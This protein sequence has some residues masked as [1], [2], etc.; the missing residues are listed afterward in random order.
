M[1]IQTVTAAV[2]SF[3]LK[4]SYETSSTDS[5][6]PISMGIPAVTIGRGGPGGRGHSLDE[7]TDVDRKGSVQAALVAVTIFLAAAGVP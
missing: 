7:W 4:P 6:I 2:T 5:N 1:L 3:G